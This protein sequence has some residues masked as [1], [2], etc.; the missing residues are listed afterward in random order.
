MKFICYVFFVL[1][2]NGNFMTVAAIEAVGTISSEE[3]AKVGAS[4]RGDNALDVVESDYERNSS[5]GTYEC[6]ELY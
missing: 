5:E 4:K 2:V 6:M 3:S 1:F